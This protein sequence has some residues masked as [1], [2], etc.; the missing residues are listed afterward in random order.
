MSLCCPRGKSN[1]CF[2]ASIVRGSYLVRSTHTIMKTNRPKRVNRWRIWSRRS[3][4]PH[5]PWLILSVE[6][7]NFAGGWSQMIARQQAQQLTR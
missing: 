1:Y 3:R 7:F 5:N 2:V 6:L 4:A